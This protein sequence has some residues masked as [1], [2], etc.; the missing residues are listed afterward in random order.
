MQKIVIVML[1]L[2]ESYKECKLHELKMIL[3]KNQL[4]LIIYRY[5]VVKH[6]ILTLYHSLAPTNIS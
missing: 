2:H 1:G 5:Y 6:N 4:N 3:N